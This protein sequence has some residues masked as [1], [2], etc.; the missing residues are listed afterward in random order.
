MLKKGLQIVMPVLFIFAVLGL[1]ITASAEQIESVKDYLEQKGDSEKTEST[2]EQE[3]TDTG[4]ETEPETETP[5]QVAEADNIGFSFWDVFKMIAATIFVVGLLYA[6]LKVINKR[7][8]TFQSTQLVENL[9]GTS[10]GNNRS[11]QIIKAGESLLIVGV[12]ENI[13]VLKEINDPDEYSQMLSIYNSKMD[14]LVQPSDIVTKAINALRNPQSQ[15]E[16]GNSFQTILKKQ[17]DDMAQS[18][19]KILDEMK[20]KGSDDK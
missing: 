5:G 16:K 14:Q 4:A 1:P 15:K 17:M 8:R 20:K 2:E 19:K 12:G 18:R 13:Q 6:L 7:N 9:G 3:E 11:I 10:L